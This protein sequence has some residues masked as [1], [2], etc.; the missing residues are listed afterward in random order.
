[1][2]IHEVV[3]KLV[4]PIDPVGDSH[5]DAERF[6]NLRTM[7]SLVDRLVADIADVAEQRDSHLGSEYA[8]LFL[9]GLAAD[10]HKSKE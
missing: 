6:K 4:G 5:F 1:M 10:V 8:D 9:R 7:A 2:D 3:T